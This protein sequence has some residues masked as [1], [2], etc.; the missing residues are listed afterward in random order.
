V[1]ARPLLAACLA[2]WLALACGTA[3]SAPAAAARPDLAAELVRL[4]EQ[5]F[6]AGELAAAEDRFARALQA[7]PAS[8]AA[9][10]G[11][12]RTALARGDLASAEERFT[13]ALEEPSTRVDARLGLARVSA[14]TG[15]AAAAREHL[16]RALEVDRWRADAHA[17]LAAVTGTAPQAA[18]TGPAP[19]GP[20][21]LAEA[22]RRAHA[23]PYD[24]AAGLAAASAL[25]AAGR[26]AEAAQRAESLLWLADLDPK[27]AGDAW[28]L[29]VRLD[30]RWREWRIVRVDS[31]ADESV[32]DDPGWEFR[33][34][35]A[36]LGASQALGPLLR[37]RFVPATLQG[38]A[39]RGT[40][41]SLDA[42]AGAFRAQTPRVPEEGIVAAFTER[43]PLRA[44]GESLGQAEFLGR[45]LAVRLE[46]EPGPSRVLLHELV[47]LYGGVHL[48]DDVESLMNPAGGSSV[49]DPLNVRIILQ[50]RQRRFRGDLESDVLAVIDLEQTTRAYE[51]A[52]RTNLFLRRA[53]LADAMQ[54]ATT[55]RFEARRTAARVRELDPHLG[56][57]ARFVAVLLWRRDN[58]ATAA[59]LL[60][61]ASQLYGPRT[62][63]GLR[64]AEE[65]ERIWQHILA[66]GGSKG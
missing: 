15:R 66:N 30:P 4:G 16:E 33:L 22:L 59:L 52:L 58:P 48:A 24:V 37:V 14:R 23:H 42:I 10:L 45:R 21:D 61:M 46:P 35:L 2:S 55:S 43:A 65:A 1:P 8:P 27:A 40:S 32:R 44:K 19:R 7:D 20:A 54:M 28:A 64:A 47:H 5:A 57:V 17:E 26:G 9:Q 6:E 56:D 12:G 18:L 63:S 13:R 38:F 29:L 36:W 11:L 34:R 60:E 51:D 39:S 62:A 3:P 53:G 25:A 50:L 41:A 49:L 31:Y